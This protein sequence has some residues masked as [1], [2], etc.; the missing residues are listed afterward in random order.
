MLEYCGKHSWAAIVFSLCVI[1]LPCVIF[2]IKLKIENAID[3]DYRQKR[4]ADAE[5][6]NEKWQ[7]IKE[8]EAPAALWNEIERSVHPINL[9]SSRIEE[10]YEELHEDLIEIFGQDYREKFKLPGITVRD[11]SYYSP[12]NNNYWAALLLAAHQGYVYTFMDISGIKIGGLAQKDM[13]IGMCKRIEYHIKK[14][15]PD[16]GDDYNLYLEWTGI[17]PPF[18]EQTKYPYTDKDS[19][20]CGGRVKLK[21]TL[22][23][24]HK[25]GLSLWEREET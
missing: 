24:G 4:H 11:D 21:L 16:A 14:H 12:A 15:H 1:L 6:R 25:A 23:L 5:S 17:T 18:E 8:V 22:E 7:K 3:E 2:Y 20:I 13:A 19:V 9:T 10:I